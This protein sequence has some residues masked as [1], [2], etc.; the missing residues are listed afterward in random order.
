VSHG[1]AGPVTINV[2]DNPAEL[3]LDWQNFEQPSVAAAV[4]ANAAPSTSHT[5]SVAIVPGKAARSNVS[6]L[7]VDQRGEGGR[8]RSRLSTRRSS[9]G[10]AETMV[11][12]DT[13]RTD[14]TA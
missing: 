4:V 8:L 5:A 10:R 12:G 6:S 2:I 9:M 1:G 11:G 14:A 7:T 3:N 13:A